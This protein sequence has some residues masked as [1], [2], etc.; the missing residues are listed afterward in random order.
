MNDAVVFETFDL[1]VERQSGWLNRLLRAVECSPCA[2]D[3]FVLRAAAAGASAVGVVITV[4]VKDANDLPVLVAA[5]EALPGVGRAP[6]PAKART[7]APAGA[8]HTH[9]RAPR[10]ARSPRSARVVSARQ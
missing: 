4:R 3:S 10:V 2:L 6:V 9:A 5:L 7:A 8:H 1:M